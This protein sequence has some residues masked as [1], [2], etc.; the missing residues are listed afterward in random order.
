MNAVMHARAADPRPSSGAGRAAAL[1]TTSTRR[2]V[3]SVRSLQPGFRVRVGVVIARLT[4]TN[5]R[6]LH[7]RAPVHHTLV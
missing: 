1:K 7:N 4:A 2:A 6:L 5:D 3:Q